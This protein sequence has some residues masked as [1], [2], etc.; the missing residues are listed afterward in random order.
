MEVQ[1]PGG[2]SS[3][4]NGNG[5]FFLFQFYVTAT[6]TVV[7]DGNFT[8]VIGGASRTV[9]T[10]FA[11]PECNFNRN[12]DISYTVADGR[13]NGTITGE[14]NYFIDALANPFFACDN[15][16]STGAVD[17]TFDLPLRNC[18]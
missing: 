13:I 8:T 14:Y 7:F 17:V 2:L 11:P 5:D 3:S 18:N 12:F 6:D 10:F 16:A 1:C 9:W 15:F 4:Y